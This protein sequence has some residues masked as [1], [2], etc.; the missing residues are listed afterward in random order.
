MTP[1]ERAEVKLEEHLAVEHEATGL[2][3]LRRDFLT[4]F[5]RSFHERQEWDH[6]HPEPPER[7]KRTGLI[8]D[9][10]L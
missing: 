8:E 6:S 7:P 3:G 4:K 5:H 1:T 2:V 9:V 10:P